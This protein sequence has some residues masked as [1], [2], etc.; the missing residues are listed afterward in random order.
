[1]IRATNENFSAVKSWAR[2]ALL[3][4]GLACIGTGAAVAD[5]WTVERQESK[6]SFLVEQNSAPIEGVFGEWSADIDF[7][8]SVPESAKI[9]VVIDTG[10]AKTGAAQVDSSLPGE[11]WFN[12][13]AFPEAVFETSGVKSLGDNEY[14]AIGDLTIRGVA[15]PV[16]L[17]FNLDI[18]GD[19]ATAVGGV[20][21]ARADWSIGDG[22]P[23]P[24]VSDMVT[25]AFELKARR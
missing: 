25:V 2:T 19:V 7:D 11:G 23:A 4:A 18:E 21:L 10:S 5:V 9:R 13:S 16:V 20:D 17:R 6:L 8:P 24:T 22:V 12:V 1:M 15:Q 14:E 3:G